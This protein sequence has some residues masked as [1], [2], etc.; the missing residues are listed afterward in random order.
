MTHLTVPVAGPDDDIDV[1]LVE[2]AA[3]PPAPENAFDTGGPLVKPRGRRRLSWGQ[4]L[5][6]L[7]LVGFA[8]L[9]GVAMAFAGG[10]A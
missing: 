4:L 8:L 1:D 10:D 7:A 3:P 9:V 2:P 5:C 6:R